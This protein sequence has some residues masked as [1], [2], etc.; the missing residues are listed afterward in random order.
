MTETD[1]ASHAG[2]YLTINNMRMKRMSVYHARIKNLSWLRITIQS[3]LFSLKD[4]D[5]KSLTALS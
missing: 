2:P 1:A 5:V 3:L 4:S